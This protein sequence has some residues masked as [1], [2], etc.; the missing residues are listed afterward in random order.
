MPRR[1]APFTLVGIAGEDD[2][3][4][5]DLAI[6]VEPQQQAASRSAADASLDRQPCGA[7]LDSRRPTDRPDQLRSAGRMKAIPLTEEDS[8]RLRDRLLAEIEALTRE[9]ELDAW[10]MRSWRQANGLA[11]ADGT[12]VRQA[13]A[14]RLDEPRRQKQSSSEQVPRST[15]QA[16]LSSHGND[17]TFLPKVT[18]QRD[19]QH[20]RFIIK[21]PCLVC[22]RQPC[23]P[24]HLRFAQARGLGQ[25][26]SDEFTV[27]LCRAHHRELHRAG[28]EVEWWSR[29]GIEPLQTA[30]TLW[31]VTHQVV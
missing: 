14:A 9:E 8:A 16:E 17:A 2:L 26:V 3:D 10:S 15:P 23:D 5:P 6:T 18:R 13:F 7:S 11:S 31:L 21:Q 28:T 12:R 29:L 19:R 1:Y 24:H 22:G 30:R 27:P 20:L 25:K 4:A